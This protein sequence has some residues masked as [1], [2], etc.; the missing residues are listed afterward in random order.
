MSFEDA[1]AVPEAF[2]TAYDALFFRAG[3]RPGESVLLHAA[4]SVNALVQLG[5]DSG[6]RGC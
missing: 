2:L 4:G 1:A 3:L 5:R 6:P